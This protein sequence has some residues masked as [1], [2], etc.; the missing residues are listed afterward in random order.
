[1]AESLDLR[2]DDLSLSNL[3]LSSRA[4]NILDRAGYSSARDLIDA[5]FESLSQLTGVGEK[6][7]QEL[8]NVFNCLQIHKIGDDKVDYLQYLGCR[9]IKLL[10]YGLAPH[11]TEADVLSAFGEVVSGVLHQMD[12]ERLRVIIQRRFGLAG[13]P[14]LTLEELALA[15]PVT[16]ER[17]RQLETSGL[18]ILQDVLVHEN[19]SN[20]GFHVHPT[21]LQRIKSLSEH[22]D[23][24]CKLGANEEQIARDLVDRLWL[25]SEPLNAEI[26]LLLTL[27]E[28]SKITF[29][30]IALAPIWGRW[31]AS[32]Q[33]KLSNA[34]VEAHK[35]LT[36]ETVQPLS[37]IDILIRINKLRK[38][39]NRIDRIELLTILHVCS[40]IEAYGEGF[41]RGKFEFLSTRAGQVERILSEIGEPLHHMDL[42][43]ELSH[44]IVHSGEGP[45]NPRTLVNQMSND[46]RFTPIGKSGEWALAEWSLETASILELM[47]RCFVSRNEPQTADQVYEFVSKR[48]PA[49]KSSINSYLA[50]D[51][52][53]A[54]LSEDLWALASWHETEIRPY[55][56]PERVGRFVEDMFKDSNRRKIPYLDIKEALIREAGLRPRQAI[57][58]L[59]M[60]PVISTE[61]DGETDELMALYNPEYKD[62]LAAGQAKFPRMK[63][64]LRD[65]A[66]EIV[67]EL[68]LASSTKRMSLSSVIAHLESELGS[69][70]RTFYSYIS[71]MD[72]V[73]KVEVPGSKEKII[74]LKTT[75]QHPLSTALNNIHTTELRNNVKRALSFLNVADIDIALFLLAK[76]F[77]AT[78]RRYID[79]AQ[80]KGVLK[81]IPPGHLSLDRMIT[82]LKKEAIIT[83]QA[84]LQ[85]LRQKRN[86]R[87][88]GPTPSLEER[89]LMMDHADKTAEMYIDY[90]RF[91]DNL[92]AELDT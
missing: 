88:H 18:R 50:F 53:F 89:R 1:M 38:R 46:E 7:I 41:Y 77:E 56:D 76:E 84:I 11:P 90:I 32:D 70:K 12:D 4:K 54:R 72:F 25:P 81:D 28:Y 44:R 24:K 85:F 30:Q 26:K 17:I 10:D 82:I 69:S 59:N 91:F 9:H 39:T 66:Q 51:D 43:R 20:Y 49:Q 65:Q 8:S 14:K 87:A 27:L 37:E 22:I 23:E 33:R 36:S 78:L 74:Q 5:E 3:H 47:E 40:S 63:P 31:R 67:N 48:R 6:T 64:T 57:G 83:D 29:P 80:E 45:I 61:T 92:Q 73:Q 55:W 15:F 58:M 16:R 62:E 79:H 68:L 71:E 75:N 52:R 13:G 34:V 86:D 35:L 42:A 2:L 60:N 19:Y 21:I